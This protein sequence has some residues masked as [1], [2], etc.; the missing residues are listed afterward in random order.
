MSDSERNSKRKIRRG[1]KPGKTKNQRPNL[2]LSNFLY[3]MS[4][5]ID[6]KKKAFTK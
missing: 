4:M 2:E 6:P 5:G 1:R 3:A